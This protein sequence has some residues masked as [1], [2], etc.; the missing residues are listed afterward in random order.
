M[1][2]I[3]HTASADNRTLADIV[4][5]VVSYFDLAV[6]VIMSLAVMIFV[7]NVFSYFILKGDNPTEKAEAGKYVMYSVVGF[8]IILSLWGLVNIATNTFDL[9]NRAP[10]GYLNPNKSSGSGSRSI[11]STFNTYAPITN[12]PSG[13][14]NASNDPDANP[15]GDS[16]SDNQVCNDPEGC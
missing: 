15:F 11:N 5:E 12:V 7:W 4:R 8:F 3:P 9:D 13:S 6:Y 16:D 14:V 1:S 10:D 2:I